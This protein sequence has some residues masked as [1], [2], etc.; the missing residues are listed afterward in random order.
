MQ[1]NRTANSACVQNAA[2]TNRPRTTCKDRKGNK[3]QDSNKT[4]DDT[5]G[6]TSTVAIVLNAYYAHGLFPHVG[7]KLEVDAKADTGTRLKLHEDLVN[8]LPTVRTNRKMSIEP[9]QRHASPGIPR[10]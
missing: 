5:N 1:N 9:G 10:L 3:Q 4:N 8:D 2:S 7:A 6:V